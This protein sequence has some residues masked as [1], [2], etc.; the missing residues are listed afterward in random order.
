MAADGPTRVVALR[1]TAGEREVL[2]GLARDLD[3]S[4]SD[5]VRVALRMAATDVEALR[6]FAGRT[7]PVI[8]LCPEHGAEFYVPI[9]QPD[10]SPICPQAG[11]DQR[12][13][14]YTSGTGHRTRA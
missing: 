5:V 10:D 14:V 7:P 6:A 11:C 12:L 3:W 13:V 9:G 1:L 4:V 2:N 8:G